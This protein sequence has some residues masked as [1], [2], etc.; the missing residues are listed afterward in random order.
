MRNRYI[1]EP[2]RVVSALTRR[3]RVRY[4]GDNEGYVTESYTRPIRADVARSRPRGGDSREALAHGL[5]RVVTLPP[6][7]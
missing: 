5:T 7:T 4:A 6:V 2:E 1:D 3:L